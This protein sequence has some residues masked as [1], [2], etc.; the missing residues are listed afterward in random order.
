MKKLILIRHANSENSSETGKDIDRKLTSEGM[1]NASLVGKYLKDEGVLPQAIISSNAQ[2][3]LLTAELVASQLE[4]PI[5][6]V[7]I[8]GNLY[9]VSV[10]GFYDFLSRQNDNLDTLLVIGHNP[11]ITYVADYLCNQE[12][13]GM[14]PASVVQINFQVQSWSDLIKGEGEFINYYDLP[15]NY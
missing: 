11:A 1:K 15:S 6:N 5:E 10:R 13:N 8:E 7:M 12:V 2:R 9:E 3:A 4:F 14:S